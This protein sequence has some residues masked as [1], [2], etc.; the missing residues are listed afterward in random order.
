MRAES[1]FDSTKVKELE[2]SLEDYA[3]LSLSGKSDYVAALIRSFRANLTNHAEI[4]ENHFRKNPIKIADLELVEEEFSLWVD[5][6]FQ[7]LYRFVSAEHFHECFFSGTETDDLIIEYSESEKE[8]DEIPKDALLEYVGRI[9]EFLKVP[10]LK[11]S[12]LNKL[13][14]SPQMILSF[15]EDSEDQGD[16]EETFENFSEGVIVIAGE[17]LE[18]TYPF[19]TVA[20]FLE[21][22]KAFSEEKAISQSKIHQDLKLPFKEPRLKQWKKVK[23]KTNPIIDKLFHTNTRGK[24]WLKKNVK[25]I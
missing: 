23:G 21:K 7:T 1:I 22:S 17:K 4:L 12:I 24:V 15:Q 10:P 25:P 5:L 16:N 18:V 13:K 2:I 20:K 3:D 6:V 19:Y 8:N 14:T 11:A 9:R